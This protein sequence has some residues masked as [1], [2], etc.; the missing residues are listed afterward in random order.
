MTLLGE[1]FEAAYRA[2]GRRYDV[3]KS[4]VRFRQLDDLP[5]EVVGEA[6]AGTSMEEFVARARAA[7]SAKRGRA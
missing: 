6:I 4:W 5:L 7:R 1:S 3:G 2:T